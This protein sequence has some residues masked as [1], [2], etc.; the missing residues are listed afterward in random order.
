M[1][2]EAAAREMSQLED[3][4]KTLPPDSSDPVIEDGA[5]YEV[6]DEDYDGEGDND[7]RQSAA[8]GGTRD[9]DNEVT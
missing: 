6:P 4:L 9:W 8:S 1:S 3:V 7:G 2:N 5:E